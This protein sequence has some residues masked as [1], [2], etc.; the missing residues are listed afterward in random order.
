LIYNELFL[1]AKKFK[2]DFFEITNL[3]FNNWYIRILKFNN[4][5]IYSLPSFQIDIFTDE[6]IKNDFLNDFFSIFDTSWLDEYIF[7]LITNKLNIKKYKLLT[8]TNL[9][10]DFDSFKIEKIENFLKN[11]DL[12]YIEENLE[13]NKIIRNNLYYLIYINYCLFRNIAWNKEEIEK[14]E[15]LIW[16]DI[17]ENLISELSLTQKRLLNLQGENIEI[18]EKYS[19]MISNLFKLLERKNR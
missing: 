15:K 17:K 8:I 3:E 18:F 4:N 6:I 11:I 1:W 12:D 2:Y 7:D 16:T 10:N 9:L 14:L 19:K 5:N 13:K